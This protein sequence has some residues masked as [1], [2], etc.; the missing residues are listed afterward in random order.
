MTELFTAETLN[1]SYDPTE[2]RLRLHLVGEHKTLALWLTR[3][4][5]VRLISGISDLL[6]R[7]SD[8]AS[9]Q[10]KAR[11]TATVMEHLA[12]IGHDS[13]QPIKTSISL[14]G[15]PIIEQAGLL[16]KVD[17]Q[18]TANRYQLCFFTAEQEVAR[19]PAVRAG[20]HRILDVLERMSQ[21]AHWQLSEQDLNWLSRKDKVLAD[22]PAVGHS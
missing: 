21:R 12:V 6:L 17:I 14:Q 9:E 10:E 19:M 16:T 8:T 15:D 3:A 20:L 1:L 22:F 7:Q 11:E 13:A 4:L 2:D 5:S 18:H